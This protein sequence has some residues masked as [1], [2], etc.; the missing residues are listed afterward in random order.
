MDIRKKA[1]QADICIIGGGASGLMAAAFCASEGRSVT[2]IE[3]TKAL[4]KK[5][6]ITGKG[7]CNVTNNC[8]LPEFME[9]VPVNP[10][11][12]YASLSAFSPQDVMRW[13]EDRGV[14]LKTERGRRVFPVSDRA[15]DIVGCLVEEC[16][17]YDVKFIFADARSLAV[18]DGEVRGVNT[19]RG[20]IAAN[21]VIMST[22]G[23]SYPLT[24]SDGSGYKIASD[25]GHTVIPPKPSLV[26][27]VSDT[28]LCGLC[29]GLSLK[30][31]GISFKKDGKELY[32]EQGEMLFTHFGVSGPVVLS[33]SA[34]LRS[35]FPLT[36]SIDL[37]PALDVKALDA[38]LLRDFGESPNKDYVNLLAGL[39]PHKLIEPFASLTKIDPHKKA[40][41]ITKQ[42]RRVIVD[43][44]KCLDINIIGTRP[45]SEAI[46]TSGGVSVREVDPKTMQSK[47]VKGLYFC[48]EILDVDAYTG[49]Y[50]LQ[51]AFS[52]A[53]AAANAASN[54]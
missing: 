48:G 12:L 18:E 27:L 2:V 39:M 14:P 47:K 45:L 54:A 25:A 8:T 21:K 35:D 23:A 43:T 52:T 32:F 28:R 31:V 30:N 15:A 40:N 9:N 19:S 16:R 51:I 38:R 29:M 11:F 50:N 34:Y 13:F 6:S 49:G 42:E 3:H 22:G 5:L 10:R 41:S 20:L 37:K 1:D 26:P 33:A 17:K 53:A 46:I 24:G 4:G 44:L 36:M 7:R